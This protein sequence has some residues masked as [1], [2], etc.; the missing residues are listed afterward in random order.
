ML[1]GFGRLVAVYFFVYVNVCVDQVL[2][3]Y[4]TVCVFASRN[5]LYNMNISPRVQAL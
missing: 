5:S 3:M 4:S 2:S 1:L